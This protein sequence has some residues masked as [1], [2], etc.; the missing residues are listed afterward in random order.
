MGRGRGAGSGH[1]VTKPFVK[2][3]A[4]HF[5]NLILH[6]LREYEPSPEHLLKR[7]VQP[8]CADI[9]RILEKGMAKDAQ[10]TLILIQRECKRLYE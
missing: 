1:Q 6:S 10:E 3:A 5:R 8:L 4:G 2:D 7:L 9:G